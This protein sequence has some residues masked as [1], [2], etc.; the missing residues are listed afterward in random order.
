MRVRAA[1]ALATC[2]G[3]GD[4]PKAPGTWA[5]LAALPLAWLIH[6]YLGMFAL[7]AAALIV[8]FIGWW[9]SSVYVAWTGTEDPAPVVID[10]I[11]GQWL[12]L[13]LA[14]P[15]RWWLLGFAMFRLFD[16]LKP[17]P[18]SWVDR[19]VTGGLGVMLDDLLAGLY[20]GVVMA[21]IL[22]LERSDYIR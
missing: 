19:N 15:A 2:F 22:V 16:I 12:A 8:F 20:G 9:A 6:N 21:A 14:D 10:E 18:V 3:I 13:V 7:L 17:W 4:L 5:S 11:A 1:L